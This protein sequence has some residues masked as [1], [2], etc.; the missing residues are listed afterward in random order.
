MDNF[1]EKTAK[2][3]YQKYGKSISDI[4]I[5][6]PNRKAGIFFKKYLAKEINKNIWSPETYSIEDFITKL[7]GFQIIDKI[8]MLFQFYNIYHSIEK[9]NAQPFDEFLNWGQ[10]LLHDFNELDL[11]LIDAKKIFNYLDEA[12][13]IAVWNLN[14]KPLTEFESKYLKFYKSLYH[15]YSFLT[16]K[17]IEK[18]Q[19]Y[20]G[21][22]YK[23]LAENIEEKID[24]LHWNKIIFIGFNAL[25]KA[26]EKIIKYLIDNDNAEIL[27]YVD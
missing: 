19:V 12:K 13:A 17:L 6:F 3:L 1:L 16:E 10:V 24:S 14:Q 20:Q 25:T 11:S 21:L 27:W 15:Y 22:A 18:K 26:E 4:C 2:Y 23:N 9:K 8:S 7:S 5:V